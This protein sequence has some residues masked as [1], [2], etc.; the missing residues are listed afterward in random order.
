MDQTDGSASVSVNMDDTASDKTD[1]QVTSDGDKTETKADMRVVIT[2]N[3]TETD[4][5]K[6]DKA[7]GAGEEQADSLTGS[8]NTESGDSVG[9][10]DPG[11]VN[12]AFVEDETEQSNAKVGKRKGHQRSPS[13]SPNKD[14]EVYVIEYNHH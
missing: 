14:D 12:R 8:D 11:Q 2:I 10:Q 6:P 3:Q 13:Y 1:D 4:D 5:S 9:S 7:G